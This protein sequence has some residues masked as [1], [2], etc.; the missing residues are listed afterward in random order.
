MT[1]GNVI[2]GL[3]VIE[4]R[5]RRLLRP[6]AVVVLSQARAEVER[7]SALYEAA[8]RAGSRSP[9]PWGFAISPDAPL[10]F[11]T[12]VVRDHQLRVDLFCNLRWLDARKPQVRQE[13]VVRVWALDD[14]V[15]LREGWDAPEVASKIDSQ[16]G[17]VMLRFHFD[18]ANEGQPGPT[19]HLQA[20]GNARDEEACWLHE[21]ISVPRLAHPPMDLILACELV[22]A[23]FC[24]V[25]DRKLLRDPPWH[26]SLCDSQNDLLLDYYDECARLVRRGEGLLRKLWNQDL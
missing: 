22:V 19:Y 13:L 5:L 26:G 3:E 6:G 23:N 18:R 8:V 24:G 20:G 15:I 16:R 17:R 7:T 11:R 10:E 9:Q 21:A 2:R 25:E 12:C 4:T 1:P 14:A